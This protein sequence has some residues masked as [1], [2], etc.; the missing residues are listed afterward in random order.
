MPAERPDVFRAVASIEP[1]RWLRRP[2]RVLRY[3]AYWDDGRIEVDVNLARYMYRRAPADFGP[4]KSAIDA[5]CP[6]VGTGAW[7]EYPY[8]NVLPDPAKRVF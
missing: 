1:S 8:G 5:N 2:R 3:D 6:P 4:V 7:V